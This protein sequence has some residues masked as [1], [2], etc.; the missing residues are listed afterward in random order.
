MK[1][2]VIVPVYN[3]EKYLE[4]CLDS[5]LDQNYKDLEVI[6]I[7]DESTD[8]SGVICADYKR[9]YPGIVRYLAQKHQGL[10][11][12]RNNGVKLAKGD[13]IIFLDSDDFL[14]DRLEL[15][16]G[17]IAGCNY[18][19]VAYSW[20]EV[21]DGQNVTD[22]YKTHA[23]DDLKGKYDTGIDFI[24]DA[25]E[26]VHLYS[27]YAWKYAYRREFWE[28]NGFEYTPGIMYEDV[29]LI[30]RVLLGSGRVA[31]FSDL[32]L[33]VY[34]VNRVGSVTTETNT[35]TFKQ[36][37][38]IIEDNIEDI[39]KRNLSKKLKTLFY[40]NFSCLYYSAVIRSAFVA[41]RDKQKELWRFLDE[42]KSVCKYTTEPRQSLVKLSI[43]FF[44]VPL[45]V[46][47][48]SVRRRYQLRRGE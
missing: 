7:N 26:K 19:I 30:Y 27:W 24:T 13:Y 37:I 10:S 22:K 3:V 6:I 46:K 45:T 40:N 39:V 47:L 1:F 21:P 11:V 48:L 2:S 8:G 15:L 14:H 31:V 4:Q 23:L 28:E 20:Y 41:D 35:D 18:D 16:A 36:S 43:K 33:Y 17:I 12:A 25:L 9:K 32:Y 38:K 34:R 5:V 44:G 29:D 42:H